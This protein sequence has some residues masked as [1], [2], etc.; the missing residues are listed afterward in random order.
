[1]LQKTDLLTSKTQFLWQSQCEFQ[2][3]HI[4]FNNI[5][6]SL[7]KNPNLGSAGRWISSTGHRGKLSLYFAISPETTC[8]PLFNNRSK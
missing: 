6:L 2:C 1:M 8:S 7:T 4:R 3:H 5:I